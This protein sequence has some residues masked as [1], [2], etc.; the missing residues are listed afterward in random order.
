MWEP[1]AQLGEK[2]GDSW[3]WA[4]SAGRWQKSEVSLGRVARQGTEKPSLEAS[5]ATLLSVVPKGCLYS[6]CTTSCSSDLA[7]L[8]T[9]CHSCVQATYSLSL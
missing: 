8:P 7:L 9:L 6:R 2:E 3:G 4:V 5:S 1:E